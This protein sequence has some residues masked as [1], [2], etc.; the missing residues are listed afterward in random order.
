VSIADDLSNEIC[1]KSSYITKIMLFLSSNRKNRKNSLTWRQGIEISESSPLRT[2]SVLA[3]FLWP[4]TFFWLCSPCVQ[5]LWGQWDVYDFVLVTS[6]QHVSWIR[7]MPEKE[8]YISV[9]D[10]TIFSIKL[11]PFFLTHHLFRSQ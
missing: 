8:M 6:L 1:T 3:A 10:M 11:P 9:S 2:C 7:C 5:S 4:Q